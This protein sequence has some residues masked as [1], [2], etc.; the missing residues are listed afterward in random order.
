[1][2]QRIQSA[3]LLLA[4]VSAILLFFVKIE[5]QPKV[6]PDNSKTTNTLSVCY[7]SEKSADN[8]TAVTRTLVISAL[9]NTIM[10]IVPLLTIFFYKKRPLQS[11]LCRL[12]ILIGSGLL[13]YLLFYLE[14]LGGTKEIIGST[15]SHYLI[16]LLPATG[17]LFS[18]LSNIFIMKDERLVKAADRIR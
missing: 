1:M 10:A 6:T 3:F 11:L 15:F 16:I 12:N 13:V 9:L 7:L 14:K 4:V 5:Y 18:Y 2:I 17:M 8:N